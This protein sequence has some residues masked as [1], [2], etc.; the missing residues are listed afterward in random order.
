MAPVTNQMLNAK[1]EE[2]CVGITTERKYFK[3]GQ[4][5]VKRSLRPSEW[6]INQYN[7]TL[8]V[9]R[10]GMDRIFNEASAIEFIAKA[11]NI[12]VPRVYSCF[13]DDEAAYLVMEYVEGITM[14]KLDV[15]KRKIVE[16][17][18][19]SHL[20]TMSK[21]RSSVWGGPSRIVSHYWSNSLFAAQLN[22]M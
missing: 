21:L 7:G 3:V 15:E 14:N 4:S 22:R 13:E 6:Q 8:V 9:P 17:E 19:E 1:R 10:F 20:E 2:N 18:V 16:K 5:W 12:P 11:T